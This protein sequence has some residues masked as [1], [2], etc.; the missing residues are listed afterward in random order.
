MQQMRWQRWKLWS[1]KTKTKTEE[2]KIKTKTRNEKRLNEIRH[3]SFSDYS[4][5]NF[6]VSNFIQHFAR[7]QNDYLGSFFLKKAHSGGR[8]NYHVKSTPLNLL[9]LVFI[10]IVSFFETWTLVIG[11]GRIHSPFFV[12]SLWSI[13]WT[14]TTLRK[15]VKQCLSKITKSNF[16][17]QSP[18]EAFRGWIYMQ[19]FKIQYNSKKVYMHRYSWDKRQANNWSQSPML[20]TLFWKIRRRI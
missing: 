14:P 15:K 16:I 7:R 11:G 17:A 12:W 5:V 13:R 1:I 8:K 18:R 2:T 10:R 4:I 6:D 19:S 9:E 20:G 3:R